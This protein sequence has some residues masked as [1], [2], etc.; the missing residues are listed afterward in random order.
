VENEVESLRL[1]MHRIRLFREWMRLVDEVPPPYSDEDN[2][3]LFHKLVTFNSLFSSDPAFSD[4]RIFN[5]WTDIL[6]YPETSYDV[7]NG[8][9]V[10]AIWKSADKADARHWTTELSQCAVVAAAL[11]T[12]SANIGGHVSPEIAELLDFTAH[13]SGNIGDRTLILVHDNLLEATLPGTAFHQ[14][15][16]NDSVALLEGSDDPV[17]LRPMGDKWTFVGPAF[18]VGLMDGEAWPDEDNI[19]EGL[20]D[21][22][23]I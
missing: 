22:I 23:L 5:A 11:I 19:V 9:S 21:F 8:E 4:P 3:D 14:A 2:G 12:N 15:M 20:Q 6:Q 1:L 18:V 16:V 17:V 10:S 7:S 13:I